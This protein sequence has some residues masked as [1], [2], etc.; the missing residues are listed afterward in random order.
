LHL[1]EQ[2]AKFELAALLR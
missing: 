1:A 2:A